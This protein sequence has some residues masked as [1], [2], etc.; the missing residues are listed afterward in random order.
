VNVPA[1]KQN[2]AEEPPA[3]SRFYMP[4][5]AVRGAWLVGRLRTRFS[6]LDEKKLAGWL[7]GM[8]DSNEALLQKT[9]H[10]VSLA[11]LMKEQLFPV[12][13]VIERFCL[14][15]EGHVLEASWHYAEMERWARGLGAKDLVVC[16]FTDVPRPMIQ[17]RITPTLM[18][19]EQVVG[20]LR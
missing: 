9:A 10:A 3:F 8:M 18:V 1:K 13:V 20:R 12:T 5:M 6:M 2:P 14:A 16:E 19:R 15:E 7:H 4:D 17:E 11:Q